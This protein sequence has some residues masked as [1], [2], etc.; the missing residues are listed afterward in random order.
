MDETSK[1]HRSSCEAGKKSRC[2][3]S[4]QIAE[5]K[6]ETESQDENPVKPKRKVNYVLTEKRAETLR[7]GREAR[8]ANIQKRNEEK[9]H[10][11]EEEK[12]EKREIRAEVA[13]KVAKKVKQKKE[14]KKLKITVPESESESS[15]DESDYEIEIKKAPRRAKS[16]GFAAKA[17]SAADAPIPPTS[18]PS[19]TYNQP[20]LPNVIFC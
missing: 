3:T 17:G 14:T 5:P 13:E 6:E 8:K 10:K 16:C 11:K 20:P 15:D 2:E 4:S 19:Q 9:T 12:Q 7:K 1:E 18:Q